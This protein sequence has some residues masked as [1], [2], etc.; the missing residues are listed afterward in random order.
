MRYYTEAEIVNGLSQVLRLKK[1][2]D[3]AR[4]LG[5]TPSYLGDVIAGRRGIGPKIAS[6]L[7]FVKQADRYVRKAKEPSK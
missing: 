4:E 1:Q 5:I 3:V 7:G 6:A 2:T